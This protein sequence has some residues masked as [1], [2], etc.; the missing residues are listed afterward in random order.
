MS[1][2]KI[3]I[4]NVMEE[5]VD[6]KADGVIDST[7]MCHCPRCRADVK[8]LALNNLPTKYVASEGGNVFMHM[9]TTT[10]QMQ[11]EI[12]V[13]IVEAVAKVKYKPS[14]PLDNGGKLK[15]VKEKRLSVYGKEAAE[16]N[17]QQLVGVGQSTA[18]NE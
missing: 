2:E 13:A 18:Q 11:A 1:E 7:E 8:A 14:H 3:S 16:P 4:I 10:T 6:L 15:K 5:I 12:M 17:E 9:Q